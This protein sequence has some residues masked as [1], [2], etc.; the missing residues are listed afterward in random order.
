MQLKKLVSS[1]GAIMLIMQSPLQIVA[2]DYVNPDDLSP[3]E[4]FLQ[5]F[6]QGLDNPEEAMMMLEDGIDTL[7]LSPR[8]Q[9][10]VSN[11]VKQ[12]ELII[13]KAP[14]NEARIQKALNT[15]VYLLDLVAL[16]GKGI[17]QLSISSENDPAAKKLLK[18]Q[19]AKNPFVPKLKIMLGVIMEITE[20]YLGPDLE[21][22]TAF[23]DE[24]ADEPNQADVTL[25]VQKFTAL[26][27]MI[28]DAFENYA[29][30]INELMKQYVGISTTEL[31]HHS[32]VVSFM[33]LKLVMDQE[34]Q[35]LDPEDDMDE[36]NEMKNMISFLQNALPQTDA[37]TVKSYNAYL[38]FTAA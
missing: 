8:E 9:F 14:T 36:I 34:T 32:R 27:T 4:A 1:V 21:E 20:K 12:F 11:I 18:Q 2:A 6:V 10:H 30:T 31:F 28:D 23:M 19:L 5:G 26:T 16:H 17:I 22:Y 37:K 15:S 13:D 25:V 33:G 7:K 35:Q 24:L 3:K 38:T 29:P